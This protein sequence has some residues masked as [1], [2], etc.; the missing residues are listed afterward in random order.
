M[1]EA[2]LPPEVTVV[3]VQI[4]LLHQIRKDMYGVRR[5]LSDLI[6]ELD[7]LE[8]RLRVLRQKLYDEATQ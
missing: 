6:A 7:A 8:S 4:N 2:P 1:N 3:H 5:S